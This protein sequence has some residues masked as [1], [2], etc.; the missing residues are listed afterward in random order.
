MLV[1]VSADRGPANLLSVE[2]DRPWLISTNAEGGVENGG[3]D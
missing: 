1:C 2:N 3:L